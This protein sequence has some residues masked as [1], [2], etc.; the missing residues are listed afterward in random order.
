ME[1]KVEHTVVQINILSTLYITID[2]KQTLSVFISFTVDTLL[3]R[4]EI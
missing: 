2:N 4:P 1:Q 3:T